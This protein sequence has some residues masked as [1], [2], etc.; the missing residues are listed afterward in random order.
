MIY[1]YNHIPIIALICIACSYLQSEDISS[2]NIKE[3]IWFE[4][5]PPSNIDVSIPI[6]IP[7]PRPISSLSFPLNVS[8]PTKWKPIKTESISN[9]DEIIVQKKGA[10]R[11][12]VGVFEY[13]D[14]NSK[15]LLINSDSKPNTIL[16]DDIV[17]IRLKLPGKKRGT[18]TGAMLGLLL[19]MLI[20]G[21]ENNGTGNQAK[22]LGIVGSYTLSGAL[23]GTLFTSPKSRRLIKFDHNRYEYKVVYNE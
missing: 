1:I 15:R 7:L 23:I 19:G 22:A 16:L 5:I 2:G 14:T 4:T 9:G 20:G 11:S 6:P 13:Y 10:L 8:I 17:M 12:I 21:V 18:F 3:T